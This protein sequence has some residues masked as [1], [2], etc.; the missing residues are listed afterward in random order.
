MGFWGDWMAGTAEGV[1]IAPQARL[2]RFERLARSSGTV[3]AIGLLER[4]Q[5]GAVGD[6]ESDSQG[7]ISIL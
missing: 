7:G 3:G 1:I 5:V 4:W 2:A 6:P